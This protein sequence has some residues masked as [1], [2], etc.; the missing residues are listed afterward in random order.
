MTLGQV[1]PWLAALVGLTAAGCPG[2]ELPPGQT[3]N[4][5]PDLAVPWSDPAADLATVLDL[6]S[7]PPR[8]SSV[9]PPLGPTIGGTEVRLRGHHFQ[10]GPGLSV[11]FDGVPASQVRWISAEELAVVPPERPA[12]PGTVSVVVI[13][14]D[15]QRGAAAQ[16]FTYFLGRLGFAAPMSW[17]VF[18]VR[19]EVVSGDFNGDGRADLAL[20]AGGPALPHPVSVMINQGSGNFPNEIGY[21]LRTNPMSLTLADVD[22]DGHPDLVVGSEAGWPGVLRGRGD[23]SFEPVREI[24]VPVRVVSYVAVA[25]LNE[26]GQPDLVA[27]DPEARRAAVLIGQGTLSFRQAGLMDTGVAVTFA[28]VADLSGDGHLDLALASEQQDEIAVLLGQGDGMFSAPLRRTGLGAARLAVG[29]LDRDGRQDLLLCDRRTQL[30]YVLPGR[31]DG[32]FAGARALTAGMQPHHVILRDLDADGVLDALV[33]NLGSGITL[34]RGRGD[35]TFGEPL[36]FPAGGG[37]RTIALGDFDGDGFPDLAVPQGTAV[38]VLRN[39]SR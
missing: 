4:P 10:A 2:T 6:P 9:D 3:G 26:D 13:N 5:V 21:P 23:G 36:P 18:P 22:R 33:G 39:I 14:P 17:P 35:G 8:I 30:L 1:R 20:I 16:A 37:F 19:R 32:T 24:A 29:D 28:A 15:G 38:Q 12:R 11:A 25:D 34:H 31:G 7:P 27:F